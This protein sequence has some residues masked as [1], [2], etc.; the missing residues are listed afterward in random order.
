MTVQP[1]TAAPA[2]AV[3]DMLAAAAAA[4]PPPPH[5]LPPLQYLRAELLQLLPVKLAP[6]SVLLTAVLPPLPPADCWLCC[7]SCWWC[8]REAAEHAWLRDGLLLAAAAAAS[9]LLPCLDCTKRCSM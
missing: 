2:V 3:M 6:V 7:C 5:G 9:G 8:C 1:S 4:T